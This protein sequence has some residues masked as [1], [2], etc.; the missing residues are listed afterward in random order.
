MSNLIYKGWTGHTCSSDNHLECVDRHH[1]TE[2]VDGR[3]IVVP[4]CPTCHGNGTKVTVLQET[5]NAGRTHIITDE[6]RE[7]CP[8]CNGS[9]HHPDTIERV[10]R[11]NGETWD[12]EHVRAAVAVLD[13][14]TGDT[15]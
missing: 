12:D 3:V 2:P 6:L 13:A 5:P 1:A 10:I 11:A 8:D 9:G 15:G 14:L 7:P 4:A